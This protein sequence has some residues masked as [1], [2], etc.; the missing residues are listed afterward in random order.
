M[1]TVATETATHTAAPP[2]ANSRGPL[3][4][5]VASG[6]DTGRDC[7]RSRAG[8][9]PVTADRGQCVDNAMPHNRIPPGSRT[10][11]RLLDAP[12]DLPRSQ[13]RRSR[14]H[15]RDDA[16]HHRRRIARTRDR[17]RVAR[18]RQAAHQALTVGIQRHDAFA[19]RRDIHPW[20]CQ[21]E[22]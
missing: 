17:R 11:R 9:G 15:Q 14:P 3:S 12:H 22:R 16:A 20:P 19:G 18:R 7:V 5:G 6:Y 8:A 1:A 21:A 13:F 10:A 4:V 2:T